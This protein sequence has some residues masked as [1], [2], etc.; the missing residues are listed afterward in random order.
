MNIFWSRV[1]L[2]VEYFFISRDPEVDNFIITLQF[3]ELE[4]YIIL[5]K[6]YITLHE[7]MYITLCETYI[8][9]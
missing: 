3:S 6:S 7:K 8:T 1:R 2:E 4:F 5:A 9:R